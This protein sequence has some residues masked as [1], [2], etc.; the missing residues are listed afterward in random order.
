MSHEVE[1]MAY[2]GQVP[3]HGLG[4]KV[5]PN[6]SVEEMLVAAGLDWEINLEPVRVSGQTVPG[7]F[8]M[9]RSSDGKVLDICGSRYKP[10]QN[11]QAF[12]F[13][14]EFVEAGD[15]ILETA[16]S[17]KEGRYVWGL[18]N[19][20]T[21]FTLPGKDKVDGYILCGCPHQQGKSLL[22]KRTA[23]RVV[24][25]N[26][27]TAA[28]RGGDDTF[29]FVH[30]S[31][32]GKS[33]IARAKR[34]LGLARE[35]IVQF[36]KEAKLLVEHEIKLSQFT[37]IVAPIMCPKASADKIMDMCD[38]IEN[39]SPRMKQIYNSYMNAP[40]AT[41][42][43]AWGVLNAVTHYCDHVASRT[44]DQRL[45]NAWFGKTARQKQAVLDKLLVLTA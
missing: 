36:G 34:V 7:F 29:R 37:S 43:N 3:W 13:F 38:D 26:T 23:I 4:E 14:R 17:L 22:F 11:H 15:A 35:D 28:L 42:G 25:H 21:S 45:T 8:G 18:A 19:L 44:Q 30:R 10:T 32:F 33:A 2:A 24:C 5:A 1:T 31:K 6:L 39:Y 16:G 12:E 41:P 20:D 27:L 9:Q 40:G